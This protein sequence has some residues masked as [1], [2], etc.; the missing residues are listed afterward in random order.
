MKGSVETAGEGTAVTGRGGGGRSPDLGL[1]AAPS[2]PA[3]PRGQ[4]I[5]HGLQARRRAGRPDLRGW[6]ALVS[7]GPPQCPVR[8]PGR[9]FCRA[10][11]GTVPSR[12]P[13]KGLR[14]RPGRACSGT[15]HH[16][17]IPASHFLAFLLFEAEKCLKPFLQP[18]L[19][20]CPA[21]SG[22]LL[23][24]G[25]SRGLSRG[26]SHHLAGL[27]RPPVPPGPGP[28]RVTAKK[29]PL[30][31]PSQ[32]AGDGLLSPQASPRSVQG[33]TVSL[34]HEAGAQVTSEVVIRPLS[35]PLDSQAS[36]CV[37]SL[38]PTP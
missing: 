15:G 26:L 2:G 21:G 8:S 14:S 24:C 9:R 13:R 5:E 35:V 7:V 29:A 34:S 38:P 17:P 27:A 31:L 18:W 11:A 37:L 4:H 6:G 3:S 22:F 25:L 36:M 10:L 23:L 28:G 19:L 20:C 30:C 33:A 1:T 32:G 16:T 12:Q